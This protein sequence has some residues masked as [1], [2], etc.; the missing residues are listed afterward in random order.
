[1]KKYL[2]LLA[3][4]L[5]QASCSHDDIII[6]KPTVFTA[7][8]EGSPTDGSSRVTLT[9]TSLN[10][11]LGDQIR[12][13]S[14]PVGGVYPVNGYF[15]STS[16]GSSTTTFVHMSGDPLTSTISNYVAAYPA[17]YVNMSG[18]Y[19]Y[20]YWEYSVS[21]GI[22]I[23]MRQKYV[24]GSVDSHAFP[25]IAYGT[26]TN[27]LFKNVSALLCFKVTSTVDFVLDSIAYMSSDYDPFAEGYQYYA[28]EAD[29]T[30]MSYDFQTSTF[31]Y[32]NGAYLR[33]GKILVEINEVLGSTAKDFYIGITPTRFSSTDVT[34]D[35]DKFYMKT[36][37]LWGHKSNGTPVIKTFNN[38]STTRIDIDR[39]TITNVSLNVTGYDS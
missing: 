27:L 39:S 20:G 7:V 24:A 12:V 28:N 3:A 25:M 31:Y 9:G 2:G 38:T 19:A 10:W 33:G 17:Q 8:T 34:Y 36:I 15:S 6:S 37:R 4:L 16:G 18:D 22:G 23:K 5:A 32:G 11:D 1:M 35:Y 26:S 30:W 21:L 13:A 29:S 14:L